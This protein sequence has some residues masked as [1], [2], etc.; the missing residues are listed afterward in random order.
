[1]KFLGYEIT[2][3]H[4]DRKA[5]KGK[6]SINGIV[7]LRVP[8]TAINARCALYHKGGQPAH[9][10]D[11]MNLDDHLIISTFGSRYRGIVQ[12]YLLASDVWKLTKLEWVMTTSMLKNPRSET[13]LNG[14]EDGPEVPG[15]HRHTRRATSML[16]GHPSTARQETT[17]RTIR[18]NSTKTAQDSDPRRSRTNP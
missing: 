10:A 16:R 8:A 5:T 6:R 13:P 17:G 15:H 14:N 1:A 9:R 2:V 12:Y 3:W 4:D 18:W 7:G 11:L